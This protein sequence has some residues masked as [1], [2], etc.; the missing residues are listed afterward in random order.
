[1]DPA[2]REVYEHYGGAGLFGEPISQMVE[3]AGNKY[4]FSA[5]ALWV[6][7][8][9]ASP[10]EFVRL[11]PLGASDYP[12]RSSGSPLPPPEPE[13]PDPYYVNGQYV[14]EPFRGLYDKLMEVKKWWGALS[15]ECAMMP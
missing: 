13:T 7:D 15:L 12:T 3:Q 10:D 6:V 2:I 5:A 9:Q 4:Q 8:A 14:Y 1:M 11:A